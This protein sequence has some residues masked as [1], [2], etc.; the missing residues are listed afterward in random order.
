MQPAP[1]DTQTTAATPP[2]GAAP[3]PQ[4]ILTLPPGPTGNVGGWSMWVSVRVGCYKDTQWE[5]VIWT[6]G[7]EQHATWL[8]AACFLYVFVSFLYIF[9]IFSVSFSFVFHIFFISFL[10][11]FRVLG[12]TYWN[13]FVWYRFACFS[14]VFYIFSV[15]FSTWNV[16]IHTCF[17]VCFLYL[18]HICFIS[19]SYIFHM[20]LIS[21]LGSLQKDA[22]RCMFFGGT[23]KRCNSL[24][25]FWG[26]TKKMQLCCII[27]WVRVAR[28]SQWASFAGH[29]QDRYSWC[30]S[31]YRSPK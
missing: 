9:Y 7:S 18:F 29:P 19:F 4:A 16:C 30:A 28:C 1:G 8:H 13:I 17:R 20:F 24:H 31:F 6:G 10:Y 5:H 11:L 26:H 2:N 25:V 27:F 12:S 22:T 3:L 23:Q 15:C 21:F 14:Y